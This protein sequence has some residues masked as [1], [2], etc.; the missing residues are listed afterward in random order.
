MKPIT[1]SIITT[2]AEANPKMPAVISTM[3]SGYFKL[4][5]L[6]HDHGFEKELRSTSYKYLFT[7]LT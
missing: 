5:V 2:N 4:S 6:S 1:I 3:Q 7:A